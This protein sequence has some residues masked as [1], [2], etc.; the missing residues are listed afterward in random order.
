MVDAPSW[1]TYPGRIQDW[2]ADNRVRAFLISDQVRADKAVRA[3]VTQFLE[4]ALTTYGD[5]RELESLL[6]RHSWRSFGLS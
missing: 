6:A 3:P 1:T 4:S 2:S 5:Y